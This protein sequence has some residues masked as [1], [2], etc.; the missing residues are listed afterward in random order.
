[1]YA[2]MLIDGTLHARDITAGIVYLAEQGF[3]KIKKTDKKFLFLSF[4]DYEV[5]LEKSGAEVPG[6]FLPHVLAL[7]F[8]PSLRVGEVVRLSDLKKN[9]PKQM[10]NQKLLH[11]LRKELSADVHREGFFEYTF[12]F[13]T[14]R[15]LVA[16]AAIA[17]VAF[18]VA[19]AVLN[20][21]FLLFVLVPLG[22]LAVLSA[23]VWTRRTA[24][25]YEAQNHLQGFKEFLS[26]TDKERFTFH[27][28]PDKNP[29]LFLAYL[30][31]AIAF[32]VEKE[33]AAVFQDITIPNPSW[34]DGGSA[35]A[36]SAAA[37]TSDMGAFSSSLSSSSGS[38]ASSGGG[39]AGG[40]AGGGGGGSW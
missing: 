38:S 9:L 34:Y 7:F 33:W 12:S 36:F 16:G 6:A 35:G 4:D 10:L 2:G 27:N 37:F 1:M 22:G 29:E 15:V 8:G 18:G 3:L 23:I 31:Y 26:V 40:G 20:A 19:I 11:T 32:G 5:T 13:S 25:G 24:K 39:S 17:V 28:A 14:P 21:A 30:P